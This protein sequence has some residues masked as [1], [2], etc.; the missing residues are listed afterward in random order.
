MKALLDTDNSLINNGDVLGKAIDNDRADLIDLLVKAGLDPNFAFQDKESMLC[1]AARQRSLKVIHTLLEAGA[2]P[3]SRDGG[4]R[5]P[6][7]QAGQKSDELDVMRELIQRGA[8]VN[9]ADCHGNTPLIFLLT[10][11]GDLRERMQVL[12]DARADVN[13]C[14]NPG[15]T[16]LMMAVFYSAEQERAARSRLLLSHGAKIDSQ[17]ASGRT[18][19]VRLLRGCDDPTALKVL[20]DAHADSDIENKGGVRRC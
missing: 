8:D 11:F 18:A 14:T 15:T 9:A 17:G 3:N 20:P 1:R 19:L 7:M 16:P 13:A 5:T 4:K 2:D 12:F 6:L 10:R